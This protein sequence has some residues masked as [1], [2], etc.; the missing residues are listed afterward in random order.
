MPLEADP[1]IHVQRI[2]AA[3]L[4]MGHWLLPRLVHVFLA[5]KQHL[6]IEALAQLVDTLSLRSREEA[7]ELIHNNRDDMFPLVEELRAKGVVHAAVIDKS[8]IFKYVE[9][10]RAGDNDLNAAIERIE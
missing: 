7:E 9:E 8:E 10:R 3:D 5:K 2:F 4:R 6:K 1:L